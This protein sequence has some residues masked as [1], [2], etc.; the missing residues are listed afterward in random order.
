MIH[1]LVLVF[2]RCV[3]CFHFCDLFTDPLSIF[4][5]EIVARPYKIKNRGEFN[6]RYKRKGWGLEKEDWNWR[7]VDIIESNLNLFLFSFLPLLPKKKNTSVDRLS[8]LNIV[9]LYLGIWWIWD[10]CTSRL[11]SNILL[12]TGTS[13]SRV[14]CWS[15]CNHH[16]WI[17]QLLWCDKVL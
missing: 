10:S 1:S 16:W 14:F 8:L 15:P 13:E 9:S 12:W 5:F 11:V 3:H 7:S 2:I 17:K 6:D 4:S